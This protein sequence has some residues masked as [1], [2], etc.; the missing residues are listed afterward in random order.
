VVGVSID[1]TVDKL[2]PYVSQMKMNYMV[3]QGLDQDAMQDAY[4]PMFGI[5]ITVVISRDGKMCSK[6]VG[7]SSKEAFEREIKSLL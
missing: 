7:L 3:L 2:K 4:G 6:H 5:P 1:D